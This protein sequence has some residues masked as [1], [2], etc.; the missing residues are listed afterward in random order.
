M[1]G[2]KKKLLKLCVA[3]QWIWE[4][5]DDFFAYKVFWLFLHFF[6]KKSSILLICQRSFQYL[7]HIKTAFNHSNFSLYNCKSNFP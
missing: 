2:Q 1:F 7:R 3:Y 4:H 5:Y 6:F